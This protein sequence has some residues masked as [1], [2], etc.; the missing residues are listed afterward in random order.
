MNFS[1]MRLVKITSMDFSTVLRSLD[2]HARDQM[3]WIGGQILK[4]SRTGGEV[5]ISTVRK[6]FFLCGLDNHNF[7]KCPR[8][9]I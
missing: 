4:V 6:K 2:M 1:T 8:C 3:F 9:N 7:Q 5:L